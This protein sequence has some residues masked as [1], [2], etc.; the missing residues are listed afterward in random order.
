M[1]IL[2]GYIQRFVLSRGGSTLL[3]I[4]AACTLVWF[5]GP[6]L[7]L[8]TK[9]SRYIVIGI[10]AALALVYFIIKRI[11]THRKAGEF[12]ADLQATDDKAAQREAELDD[13]KEKMGE[14]IS[15]LKSSELGIKNK[16]DTA[17]YAL[18][19][20]MVIGPPAAGKST[21]LRNSGLHFPYNRQ[22]DLDVK[23]FGGT[24]NCDWWFSDDAVLLD[25]AGRY[26]TETDDNEE[27]IAFLNLLKKHRTHT[28]INGVVVALSI[29][30]ILTQDGLAMETHVNIVRERIEELIK[31]LGITFPVYIVFTKCDLLHGFTSFYQ[32]GTAAEQEQV[33]GAY[34]LDKNADQKDL[35]KTVSARLQELYARL[36]NIRTMKLSLERN[37]DKKAE[38]FDFPEQFKHAA[39]RLDEFIN[40]L[41]KDN[42][43]QDTPK[44]YGFYFT[45]G[46]QEGTSIERI[47]GDLHQ[48]FGF[49]E[50]APQHDSDREEEPP[51]SYF[52]NKL[53]KNVIFKSQ[54]DIDKSKGQ[55]KSGKWLKRVWVTAS[56]LI[57]TASVV[58][59]SASLASNSWLLK[60]GSDAAGKLDKDLHSSKLTA[61][62]VYFG[63]KEVYQQYT[64]ITLYEQALPLHLRLGIYRADKQKLPLKKIIFDSMEVSLAGRLLRVLEG[65]MIRLTSNWNNFSETK[66]TK[67]REDLYQYLRTYLMLVFTD[68][69]DIDQASPVI[70]TLWIGEINRTVRDETEH[71][72]ERDENEIGQIVKLYLTSLKTREFPRQVK[73]NARRH[74]VAD[75]RNKL[76]LTPT[77]D[78]LYARIKGLAQF[79]Y[80]NLDLNKLL[81]NNKEGVLVST[82]SLPGMF[83]AQAWKDFVHQQIQ[84]IVILAYKGDWVLD[85]NLSSQ[86]LTMKRA[87][88]KAPEVDDRKT[89]VLR[90]KIR[91]LYFNEYASHWISLIKSLKINAFTSMD[92]ATRK[93]SALIDDEG[94]LNELGVVLTRNIELIDYDHKPA[95]IK[96][97]TVKPK[98]PT[99][100]HDAAKPKSKDKKAAAD[101]PL[102]KE[103]DRA[104]QGLR[105]AVAAEKGKPSRLIAKYIKVLSAIKDDLEKLA[106]SADTGRDSKK[107]AAS[108]LG[109]TSNSSALY[110]GW[111]GIKSSLSRESFNAREALK[112]LMLDPIKSSW[113][114]I[115]IEAKKGLESE[116]QQKVESV[117]KSTILNRFPFARTKVDSSIK[118]V[119]EFFRPKTGVYWSFVEQTL[120]PFLKKNGSQWASAHWLGHG[121]GV[122]QALFSNIQ[123]ADYVTRSLFSRN[124]KRIG[125]TFSLNPVPQSGIQQSAIFFNGQEYKYGNQPPEWRKFEWPGDANSPGARLL[126]VA[127]NNR[128]YRNGG[129][130]FEV[131]R[132][133]VWGFFHLL[134]DARVSGQRG[135]QYRVSWR[136]SNAE[137]RTISWR[138]RAASR[139]NMFNMSKFR[140]FRM[141]GSLFQSGKANKGS[142][143]IY[144]GAPKQK[145]R[146]GSVSNYNRP[147]RPN[148]ASQ[149]SPV[150][151]GRIRLDSLGQPLNTNSKNFRWIDRNGSRQRPG[152]NSRRQSTNHRHSSNRDPSNRRTGKWITPPDQ[153]GRSGQSRYYDRGY[154]DPRPRYPMQRAPSSRYLN[155]N[156]INRPRVRLPR[157][158]RVQI[159]NGQNLGDRVIQW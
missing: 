28:P 146:S 85:A 44:F 34:L 92:D 36:C 74:V 93:I 150:P 94:P 53:F 27:W 129:F 3:G 121:I 91:R 60:N 149:P 132:D 63:L 73:L 14:V 113:T 56:L 154:S 147:N 152:A 107:Y 86:L 9:E 141:P 144:T 64:D 6:R 81:E 18:P 21:M 138:I 120:K 155:Q 55:H 42:P 30:D 13:M 115:L 67:Y 153:Q 151:G 46:A 78:R 112:Y 82:V 7:G 128:N 142:Q 110:K 29:V 90:R 31:H 66:K 33:W 11:I 108:I 26:T 50:E 88:Q 80:K 62:K 98:L 137:N 65:K 41:F 133:G 139:N 127:D 23:G 32:D 136:V 43:Y 71:L 111:V 39:N 116:W 143:Q 45:S 97:A 19:W 17:L 126:V 87:V 10:I 89:A 158:P 118:D 72:R 70:T 140:R 35:T 102:V 40:L 159:M 49:V 125:M 52:I 58:L 106:E 48:S 157:K 135:G 24:R 16:G 8:A 5:V 51:K 61:N 57:I 37:F 114:V 123:A 22:E 100:K 156:N 96:V 15:S 12:A 83:T 76:K 109:G 103:M 79:K 20:Y 119:E 47:V 105:K 117:Y 69:I 59:L 84:K 77:A 122:S 130:R 4:V 148:R 38:I 2:F 131:R 124:N 99:D 25:T 104:L 145:A 68:W 134:S 75:A 95:L 1:S 54:H 101:R